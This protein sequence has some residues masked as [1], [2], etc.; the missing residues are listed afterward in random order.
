MPRYVGPVPRAQAKEGSMPQLVKKRRSAWAVLAACAMFASL[1]AVAATPAGAAKV[2]SDDAESGD[3]AGTQACLEGVT[4]PEDA[5]TDVSDDHAHKGW[6]DCIAYYGITLGTGDGTTFSPN[7]NIIRAQAATMIARAATVAG[8]D[9]DDATDDKFDDLEGVAEVH[10]DSINALAETGLISGGG[11]FRPGDNTT[12]ADMAA[13][14]AALLR[15]T[16]DVYSSNGELKEVA[17][18]DLD[19][20]EDAR[21]ATPRTVDIAISQLYELGVAK[22]TGTQTFNPLGDLTRGQMAAFIT[23]ALAHTSAR[24]AGITA[25]ADKTSLIVSA[26]DENF[27]PQ[28]NVYVDV[29][30]IATGNVD[31][32]LNADGTCDEVEDVENAGTDLC[33]IDTGDLLTQGG[34][35]DTVSL[36]DIPSGGI[37]VWAW[38]GA[39][40]DKFGSDT[41]VFRVDVPEASSERTAT[42]ARVTSDLS[43]TKA[44]LGSSVVYT[45]QL[46]DA[47]GPV[48][49]TEAANFD[50]RLSRYA[51]PDGDSGTDGYQPTVTRGG[52]VSSDTIKIK[53]DDDGK[54]TFSVT[55]PAGDPSARN[56]QFQVDIEILPGEGAPND[57]YVGAD[58]KTATNPVNNFVPVRSG[59]TASDPNPGGLRFSAEP[60]ASH[61]GSVK[62][63]AVSK[64]VVTDADGASSRVKV[65]VTDQYGDPWKG[66]RVSFASVVNGGD[67]EPLGAGRAFAVDRNGSYT[68]SYERKN[69]A[70]ASEVVTASWD[71]DND[72]DTDALTGNADV[73][74]AA[75][76]TDA[77]T[78]QAIR[79]FDK[80]T[81][82]IFA[83]DLGGDG[84]VYV[85]NYD[86]GDRFN[87]GSTAGSEPAVT[88]AVFESSL[89][90]EL[91]LDWGAIGTRR[92]AINTFRLTTAS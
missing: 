15:E 24:P 86:S 19:H 71:H 60:R 37:T 33:E 16:S 65:T 6:I 79:A 20:F 27:Q 22:G 83:G 36:G 7:E 66:A 34:G 59:L 67:S 41:E 82:T 91:L 8:A 54:A 75:P 70:A 52:L 25:Q 14:V 2:G 26:R 88:Y 50:V 78:D 74:W 51:L 55:A 18:A 81:N 29:F 80:D 5:F 64:F 31:S 23:R 43:G 49:A 42:L 4:S 9:L 3:L 61:G 32:A 46:E 30:K 1:L 73:E 84:D 57:V 85:V 76:A 87:V 28:A 77:Q 90:E 13:M 21:A 44:R 48:S 10:R 17:N 89:A 11:N 53:T 56:D 92:S 39:V 63:E 72:S 58:A 68:L 47:D 38:T 12:R 45:V 69:A 62:L 35:D 40:E